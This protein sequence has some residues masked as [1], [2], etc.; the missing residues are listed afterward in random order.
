[1]RLVSSAGE[2]LRLTVSGESHGPELR[3]ELEGF[4]AGIALDEKELREFMLR[5]SPGRDGLSSQRKEDDEIVFVRGI[6]DG[7]T[8]GGVIAGRIPNRD[9]RPGDYGEERTVPRPGHADFPQWVNLG[10]I[11]TGGGANSGRLTAAYC[12]AG[13][14]CRQ[15]LAANGVRVEARIETIHGRKDGFEEEIA[16]ARDEGDSVGGTIVCEVKGLPPGIG[17]P[18]FEGVESLLSSVVFGIPG[19]KG[20]EFGDAFEGTKLYGSQYNDAFCVEDGQVRTETNR[21]AGILGGMTSGMPVV[22]RVAVRPTPTVFKEQSSV[23]LASMAPAKL[24]MKGRHDPCIV[25]RALPVVE[26]M[27]SFAFADMMVPRQVCDPKICLTLTGKTLAECLAQYGSQRYFTD[28]VEL[29]ADLLDEAERAKAAE[30]TKMVDVP[31]LLTFRRKR[32]GGAFEGDE[33]ERIGFFRKTL[34]SADPPF[35]Y[36]DFEEDFIVEELEDIVYASCT[37]IVRSL[38]D[39]SGPVK[40][41]RN[42]MAKMAAEGEIAKIAFMPKSRQDVDRAFRELASRSPEMPYVVVAMGELGL[43]TRIRARELGSMWT[44]ASVGGLEKLGHITPQELVR[45]GFRLE[46]G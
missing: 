38:H 13:G 16:K 36:V 12:A 22:F 24:S 35:A 6:E 5:R 33:N 21:Q 28:M 8:D 10:R 45:R 26:A 1:M 20:I 15:Y 40:S 44:Y 30:F 25:R 17:G 37:I 4:P 39:F 46:E 2:N 18:M 29:R 19:V 34:Q 7:E 11:P 3:F 41:L 31:V 42:R 23:D 14:I 32:E 9:F 43:D 27:A